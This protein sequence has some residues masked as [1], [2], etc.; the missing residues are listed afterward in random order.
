MTPLTR[1]ERRWLIALL[2]VALFLRVAYSLSWTRANPTPIRGGDGVGY[3]TWA[4]ASSRGSRRRRAKRAGLSAVRRG[5]QRLL[6]QGAGAILAIRVPQALSA[7][8]PC[9]SRT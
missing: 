7:S 1:S 5:W 8:R 2:A 4:T 3:S 9:I 6:G